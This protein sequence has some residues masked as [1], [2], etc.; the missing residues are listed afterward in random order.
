MA[1]LKPT[2]SSW[3]KPYLL[4]G[5]LFGGSERNMGSHQPIRRMV[6]AAAPVIPDKLYFRI[7]DTD[8]P[9]GAADEEPAI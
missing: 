6:V 9:Y 5:D 2:C 1:W 4:F 8:K 3:P 7:G